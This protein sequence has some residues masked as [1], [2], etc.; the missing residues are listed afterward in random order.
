MKISLDT[1]CNATNAARLLALLACIAPVVGCGGGGGGSSSTTPT[2]TRGAM[3][4]A[5]PWTGFIEFTSTGCKQTGFY[6]TL[7][8]DE[9]GDGNLTGVYEGRNVSASNPPPSGDDKYRGPLKG[10]LTGTRTGDSVTFTL[11]GNIR[12]SYA[13]TLDRGGSVTKLSADFTGQPGCSSGGSGVSDGKI[14]FAG[15]PMP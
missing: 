5:S 6:M 8:F 10:T 13:G 9:T 14:F 12:G 11:S 15:A 3:G 2:Q 4:Q 7:T 1:T